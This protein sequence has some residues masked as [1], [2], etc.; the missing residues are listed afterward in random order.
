IINSGAGGSFIN[1]GFYQKNCILLH[2]LKKPFHI[3]TANGSHST[4]GKITHY[5]TLYI[6][7]D[8]CIMWGKFNVTKLSQKDDMLL[9][10]PWLSTMNPVIDW[11]QNTISLSAN[12]RSREVE[13]MIND[14]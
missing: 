3:T 1:A 4:A 2:E 6:R 12:P 14:K 5:C 10:K 8:K 7:L 13:Q 11:A 9:G